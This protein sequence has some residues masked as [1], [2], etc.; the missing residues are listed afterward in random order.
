MIRD[1][2]TVSINDTVKQ[3]SRLLSRKD[4]SGVAVIVNS[5]VKFPTFYGL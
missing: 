5:G 4:I 1:V 2:V 3:I